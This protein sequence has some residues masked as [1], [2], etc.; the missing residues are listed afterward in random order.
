VQREILVWGKYVYCG[1]KDYPA[2]GCDFALA[3]DFEGKQ[4]PGE[5]PHLVYWMVWPK[6]E[7]FQPKEYYH[8]YQGLRE[9]VARRLGLSRPNEHII[10]TL[11]NDDEFFR[12]IWYVA[13]GPQFFFVHSR[14][15]IA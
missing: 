10:I 14:R 3:L 6:G 8:K 4:R 12:R 5:E 9:E 1:H 11:V 15:P 13:Q 2:C 7:Q